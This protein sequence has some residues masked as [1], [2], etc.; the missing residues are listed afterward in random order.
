ME[1][2]TWLSGWVLE[3]GAYD[4]AGFISLVDKQK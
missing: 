3:V 4:D 1:V 2:A